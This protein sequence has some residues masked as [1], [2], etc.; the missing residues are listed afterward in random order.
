[1]TL[2][3]D[4]IL[5]ELDNNLAGILAGMQDEPEFVEDILSNLDSDIE[6]LIQDI[7]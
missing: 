3:I 2:Y 4:K 1:M 5:E 6:K 7:I